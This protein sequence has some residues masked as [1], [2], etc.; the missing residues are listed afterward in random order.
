[1]TDATL[2]ELVL[3]GWKPIPSPRTSGRPWLSPPSRARKSW[4]SSS[5]TQG[6]T[7]A[8][9]FRGDPRCESQGRLHRLLGV[10]KGVAPK[11][12]LGGADLIEKGFH[13]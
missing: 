1:M 4:L 3:N 5:M 10:V 13:A 9:A 6:S 2:H 8:N 12:E 11:A 7:R